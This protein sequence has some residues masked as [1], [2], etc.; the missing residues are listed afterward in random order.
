[1]E[2]TTTMQH[3]GHVARRARRCTSWRVAPTFLGCGTTGVDGFAYATFAGDSGTT[4]DAIEPA[5]TT[6]T[7]PI[8]MP[9][10]RHLG[11]RPT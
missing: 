7:N 4:T 9:L 8:A 10:A 11:T 6:W 3:Q 5:G 2:M 1:M